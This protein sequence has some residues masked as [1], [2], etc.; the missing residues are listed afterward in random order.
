MLNII[1]VKDSKRNRVRNR[2]RSTSSFN[3][4]ANLLV[5]KCKLYI[6]L[7]ESNITYK[8]LLKN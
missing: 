6:L 8:C 3:V 4:T 2:V 5:I 1:A 7:Y